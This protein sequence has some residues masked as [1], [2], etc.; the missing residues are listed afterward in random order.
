MYLVKIFDFNFNVE[1]GGGGYNCFEI[2]DFEDLVRV[3]FE[4]ALP[5]L[6]SSFSV[7]S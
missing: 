1:V 7:A 5:D 3:F 2:S 6:R 4:I